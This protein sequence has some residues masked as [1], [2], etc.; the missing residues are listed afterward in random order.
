[1]IPRMIEIV[2]GFGFLFPFSCLDPISHL[3]AFDHV[4][5][6]GVPN[7]PL[8]RAAIPADSWFQIC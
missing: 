2:R 6:P 3:H 5:Q 8:R 1:M 7:Q 4:S